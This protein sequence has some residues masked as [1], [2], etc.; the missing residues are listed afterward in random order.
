MPHFIRDTRMS[1][2][3][4]SLSHDGGLGKDLRYLKHINYHNTTKRKVRA[5]I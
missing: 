3:L 4:V 2:L 1:K 5:V